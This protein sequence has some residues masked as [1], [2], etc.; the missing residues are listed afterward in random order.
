MP[1]H[2]LKTQKFGTT[3]ISCS[4][5]VVSNV[6][7]QINFYLQVQCTPVFISVSLGGALG[8]NNLLILNLQVFNERCWKSFKPPQ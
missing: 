3:E 5:I 2:S 6:L 8:P 4:K 7:T 1:A